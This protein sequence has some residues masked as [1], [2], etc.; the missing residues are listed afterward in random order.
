MMKLKPKLKTIFLRLIV[1]PKPDP[2]FLRDGDR[3]I[4]ERLRS[5][6][7][8][9]VPDHDRKFLFGPLKST[10][11]L[12]D[13]T[14]SSDTRTVGSLPDR[15]FQTLAVQPSGKPADSHG[16]CRNT[17]HLRIKKQE[18]LKRNHAAFPAAFTTSPFTSQV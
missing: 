18:I 3:R 4:G 6:L 16:V 2:G 15:P 12:A 7:S 11:R 10:V 1:D 13:G 9:K 14:A 17:M 8:V 5:R